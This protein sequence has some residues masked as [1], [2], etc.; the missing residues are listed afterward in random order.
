VLEQHRA[1]PDRPDRVGD[2]LAGD[3][4]RRAVDGLE[5][6]RQLA[7][8]VQVGRRRD[9]DG[10]GHRRHEVAEDVAEEVRRDDDVEAARA[11]DEHRGQRVDVEL[12]GVQ[13]GV[14]L[15]L[16]GE[17]LVPEGHRVDD[18][19]GLGGRGQAS[20]ARRGQVAREGDDALHAAAGE[21]RLLDGELL[22][23]PLVQAPADLRVLALV[24][25][26]DDDEV[27]VLRLDVAQ[28]RDDPRAGAAPGAGSRTGG[29]RGGSG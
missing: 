8:G 23:G 27:Q 26:A 2:P 13:P 24:V 4:R 20:R 17:H 25:L 15:E 11:Q 10:A 9:A 3:V 19:V 16:L 5:H 6:R 14:G 12:I 28:G 29:T 18:P 7:P 22:R 1:R 21:R